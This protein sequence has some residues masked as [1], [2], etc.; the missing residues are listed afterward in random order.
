MF[1]LKVVVVGE[2]GNGQRERQKKN[3]ERA[4]EYLHIGPLVFL[5]KL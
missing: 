4:K 3:R 5:F 2:C 1:F